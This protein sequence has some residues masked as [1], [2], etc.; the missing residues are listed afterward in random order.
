MKRIKMSLHYRGLD[1]SGK[2]VF[3][4]KVVSNLT[5][6]SQ[7]PISA[8]LVPQLTSAINDLDAAIK[9]PNPNTTTIKAKVVQLE[10]VLY[11]IKAQV[12]L[13]CN[14][15]EEIAVNSGFDLATPRSAKSKIFTVSQGQL[16]GTV[17][18]QCVFIRNAAYVWEQISDPINTNTWVQIGITNTT[19]LAV[20]NL[21]AGNKYWFR[22]KAIVKDVQQA[23]SD[24]YMIH[25]I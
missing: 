24:P 22:A 23:Y 21:V 3:G 5:S 18:L 17:N 6:N 15:D 12:E 20:A 10:K 13:E 9:A 1:P 16:S 4:T 11:V 8:A 2:V 19:N 7:L 25:V 14:D